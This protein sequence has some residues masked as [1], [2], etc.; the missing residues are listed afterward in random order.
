[1]NKTKIAAVILTVGLAFS[2]RAQTAGE[3]AE[4]PKLTLAD[5]ERIALAKNPTVVQAKAEV[6]AARGR[7]LQAGL[8]PNPV[9]GYTAE[10]FAYRAGVG[11]GKQGVFIEQTIPLGGKLAL[12]RAI[13]ENEI[14]EAEANLETQRLRVINSIRALYWESVISARRVEVRERLA[15]LTDEAVRTSHQLY[16]TGAADRPDVLEAEIESREARLALVAARNQQ[17]H[18]WLSLATMIGEPERR[19]QPLGEDDE[20]LPELDRDEA[21]AAL[22]RESPQLQSAR[23]RLER[24]AA[25]LR[26]ADRESFPD[27]FVRFGSDYDRQRVASSGQPVAVGWEASGEIGI[28]IPLFDRNQG[29]KEAARARLERSQAEVERV[30][31]ALRSR[32]SAI[33]EAY[34]N[35]LRMAEEYSTEILPRAEEAHRL[36]LERFREMA[37]AYPQ[38]LIAQRTLFQTSERYLS[39]LEEVHIAALQIR[40]FLVVDGLEAPPVP[41]E[42]EPDI[43][44]SELP[45]AVRAGE[46]PISIRRTG[47]E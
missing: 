14:A 47:E 21:V 42:S 23:A 4:P 30:E 12:G 40:G 29:G 13:F 2:A 10:D 38:V 44:A 27:L 26:R 3:A 18:T 45:G 5:L 32:V 6:E 22:L 43:R 20:A 9:V 41:G 36:Y 25:T 35:A 16:N 7:A 34:L 37:A 31:L 24:A 8:L 11:Q 1:V 46:L 28:S 39:A 15:A 17:H 19:V 33:F